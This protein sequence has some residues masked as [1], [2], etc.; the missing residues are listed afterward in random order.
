MSTQHLVASNMNAE[1]I[2][3]VC[4][5]LLRLNGD[6]AIVGSEPVIQLRKAA[7]ELREKLFAKYPAMKRDHRL[8]WETLLKLAEEN[9]LGFIL[10]NYN[11]Q[12]QV[13]E[14]I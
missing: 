1:Q 14:T 9:N 10:S 11:I 5:A 8:R 7:W 2:K 3:T 6:D 4:N 13:K 12:F